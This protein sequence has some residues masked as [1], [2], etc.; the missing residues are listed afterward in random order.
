MKLKSI[1][2]SNILSFEQ[3]NNIDECE[4]ILFDEKLNILIGANG[5]G[6]SNFLEVLNKIFKS[7]L[8]RGCT[9]SETILEKNPEEPNRYPLHQVM[10]H[11]DVYHNLPK[12]YEG[13][14]DLKEIKIKLLLE[15]SD[16]D[17]LAFILKNMEK[18]EEYLG[19]YSSGLQK[20]DDSVTEDE[21]KK[22]NI[23][24]FHF[25]DRDSSNKFTVV[26]DFSNDKPLSFIF[27]Y[28][29]NYNYVQNVI[30]LTNRI[31]GENWSP[32]KQIMT[33]LSSYRNYDK[34]TD[35]YTIQSNEFDQLQQIYNKIL[36]ESAR[37]S[38]EKEPIIFD[39]VKH[40]FSHI[41]NSIEHKLNNAKLS[42]PDNKTSLDFLKEED[43]V[44]KGIEKLLKSSLDLS[45]YIENKEKSLDYHFSFLN[46]ASKKVDVFDLSSGEKGII[47][48]IFSLYGYDMK[49]GVM[50]I[51]E[52]ELHLHPQVQKKYL[53]IIGEIRD[54]L[55][56]QFI[57]ATHSSI[58]VNLETID[59]VKR[60]YMDDNNATKVISPS[61]SDKERDLVRILSYTNSSKIFFA[62]RVI[63]VE[64]DSDEYFFRFYLEK[65]KEQQKEQKKKIETDVEFLYI[66]GKDHYSY[67]KK[68]LT[69]Y[70][71]IPYFVGD[72]DNVS[73]GTAKQ[74][75]AQSKQNIFILSQGN[76]ENYIDNVKSNKLENAID[77]TKN[78]YDTWK[79][80]AKNA[81]K[82]KELDGIFEKITLP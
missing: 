66:G 82:I 50:I 45:L 26:N 39:L 27:T 22:N 23:V 52:P 36:D 35:K 21:I 28:F 62:K 79:N 81:S 43:S 64:G 69:E 55:G 53:E 42:N 67:W 6:K 70:K 24:E 30:L 68:F 3:K 16:Y 7:A 2:I 71:I 20:F 65:Y 25:A 33:L 74:I 78:R 47:H 31:H 11:R 32:L 73:G 41:M 63:L 8:I 14:N 40:R 34:I 38:E 49:D 18:M 9:F 1:K 77:F 76:L 61:I 19:T 46:S 56:T 5:S 51:D 80:E 15:Q 13:D 59:G 60:F 17:N 58:F 48:F 54:E 12:N 4:E 72:L 44:F 37:Q 57:L 10:T 75:L 29:Q